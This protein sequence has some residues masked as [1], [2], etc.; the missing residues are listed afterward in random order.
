MCK[1]LVVQVIAPEAVL[2]ETKV[3]I[4]AQWLRD[5]RSTR[6]GELDDSR[7]R[8]HSERTSPELKARASRLFDLQTWVAL[9][10]AHEENGETDLPLLEAE[11]N[12][13]E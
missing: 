4:D 7:A 8:Q 9:P 3:S 2:G 13:S 6:R 12:V 1:E 5:G 11:G 10:A